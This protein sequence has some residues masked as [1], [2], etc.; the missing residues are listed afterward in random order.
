MLVQ[1]KT[2]RINA[3]IT[4]KGLSVIRQALV[5]YMPEARIVDE[6][7]D[8]EEFVKWEETDLYSEIKTLET[9]GLILGAYRKREGLSLS[10]LAKKTGISYTN[11][12]AMEH[13]RR[14]IG[15]TSA[16]RLAKAL[17]FDYRRLLDR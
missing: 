11:I 7:G 17:G 4:G 6:A 5:E 8:D 3:T 9:Q 1:E 14:A 10:E 12:S 16:K 13:D 2:R 15:I